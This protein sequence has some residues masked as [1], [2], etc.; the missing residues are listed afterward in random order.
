[1]HATGREPQGGG[2]KQPGR[3]LGSGSRSMHVRLAGRR[4][5]RSNCLPHCGGGQVGGATGKGR[6]DCGQRRMR[7]TNNKGGK[8]RG[9]SRGGG[10]GQGGTREPQQPRH[11]TVTALQTVNMEVL[12]PVEVAK[13]DQPAPGRRVEGG[14]ALLDELALR[15]WIAT[16]EVHIGE[17]DAVAAPSHFHGQE[18]PISG[19]LNSVGGHAELA[20]LQEIRA[21]EDSNAR[22]GDAILAAGPKSRI[23]RGVEQ[24]RGRQQ[25]G[26]G[27]S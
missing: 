21:D 16:R 26:L 17:G 7:R 13:Q 9:R 15:N 19:T 24:I 11:T 22:K 12:S 5:S 10:G 23:W 27:R 25:V 14:E 3:Q 6:N 2:G 8:R 20:T 18:A 1:M 4:G